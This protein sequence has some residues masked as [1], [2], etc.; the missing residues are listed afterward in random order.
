MHRASLRRTAEITHTTDPHC[1]QAPGWPWRRVLKLADSNPSA[2]CV[3]KGGKPPTTD[4]VPGRPVEPRTT[5]SG[6]KSSSSGYK[7]VLSIWF[8]SNATAAIPNGDDQIQFDYD[9][10]G[11]GIPESILIDLDFP[12]QQDASG[13]LFVPLFLITIHDLAFLSFPQT[14]RRLNRAYLTWATRVSAR[15]AS[16][17]LAVSEATK[18]EIVR[19]L[20]VPPEVFL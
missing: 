12:P 18:Q 16:R 10:D 6:S 4:P 19:L 8:T 1:G 2:D 20:G 3:Q 5:S 9:N 11:D 15:R 14:F 13:K 17:I 7:S